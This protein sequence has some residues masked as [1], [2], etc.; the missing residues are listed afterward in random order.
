MA[1]RKIEQIVIFHIPTT[2]YLQGSQVEVQNVS[3][4]DKDEKEVFIKTFKRFLDDC[5]LIWKKYKEDLQKLQ[6]SQQPP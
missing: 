2:V 5:F 4:F 6:V 3:I 1:T